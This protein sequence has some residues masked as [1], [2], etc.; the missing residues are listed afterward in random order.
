MNWNKGSILGSSSS[1]IPVNFKTTAKVFLITNIMD[2]AFIALKPV[3]VTEES[4]MRARF[5][6][7]PLNPGYGM[8]IG[9][10]LR[11]ILLSSLEGHAISAIQF[12]KVNHEFST[13]PDVKED[14]VEIILNAK[15]VRFRV[16]GDHEYPIR[17]TLTHTGEGVVKAKEFETPTG[18][19]VV[20]PDVIIATVT[21]PDA[22][23]EM[24]A[25]ISKGRGFDPVEAREQSGNEIGTI[26]VDSIFSPVRHV[27][28][29]IESVRVG[30]MTN[31]NKVNL[32]VETDGSI[33]PRQ[34]FTEAIKIFQNHTNAL[35]FEDATAGDAE[36]SPSD[37]ETVAS[38]GDA[39][40]DTSEALPSA[41]AEGGDV[42]LVSEGEK[43]AP[44]RGRKKKSV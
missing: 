21:K 19:E 4:D 2:D 39:I 25:M 26:A 3:S 10:P 6:I 23:F 34:A 18:V 35:R 8:T 22:T 28:F 17:I 42:A 24:S 44:K 41:D 7:E 36:G 43:E 11:R 27:A 33:S 16:V 5:T 12:S 13:L 15:L 9:N 20:S 37:R 29:S 38:P 40:S 32:M 1:T 30:Q 14:I 31:Y